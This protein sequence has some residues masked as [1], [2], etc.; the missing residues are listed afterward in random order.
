MRTATQN[1]RRSDRRRRPRGQGRLK[2]LQAALL[3][4]CAL[5][6][7]LWAWQDWH[8]ERAE[9]SALSARS[10]APAA[11]PWQA[12]LRRN[13]PVVALGAALLLLAVNADQQG[14]RTVRRLDRERRRALHDSLHDALTRLPNRRAFDRW[15]R[16]FAAD[17]GGPLSLLL[18]D[19]DGFKQ[20]N[21]DLGHEV[22][23]AAL[24]QVAA[25]LRATVKPHEGIC[26]RWGGDEFAVLL[27]QTDRES[28]ERVAARLEQA[29][30]RVVVGR[31]C[32]EGVR[33][34][35]S[36]GVATLQD[37]SSMT[38]GELLRT[39]DDALAGIKRQ[40]YATQDSAERSDSFVRKRT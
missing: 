5:L 4:V 37:R 34:R 35:G 27:P 2:L 7:A 40:R 13:G 8:R 31:S 11:D 16:R 19:L 36:I 39:A 14:A 12:W 6:G 3:A 28:A 9:S 25:A 21:D 29:L 10:G 23:D 26:C 17:E 15:L 24:I 1:R 22:G 30:Q 38:G 32:D 33:V 20:L 18:V